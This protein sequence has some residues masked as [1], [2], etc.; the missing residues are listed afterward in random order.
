LPTYN[1][2][3]IGVPLDLDDAALVLIDFTHK[4]PHVIVLE[5]ASVSDKD[6]AQS[7]REI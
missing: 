1:V 6:L 2:R 7:I 5:E 3:D 4:K